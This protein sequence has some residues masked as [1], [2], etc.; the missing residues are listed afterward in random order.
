MKFVLLINVQTSVNP[1]IILVV[2]PQKF[3]LVAGAIPIAASKLELV[4]DG[5][6]ILSWVVET[7][8]LAYCDGGVIQFSDIE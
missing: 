3:R 6:Q 7:L 8:F 2:L 1:E 5:P 4:E